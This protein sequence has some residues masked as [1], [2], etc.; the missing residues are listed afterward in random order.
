MLPRSQAGKRP[1]AADRVE[2]SAIFGDLLTMIK[3]KW[4]ENELNNAVECHLKSSNGT[5]RI[6]NTFACDAECRAMVG[7]NA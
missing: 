6:G 2:S 3:G 4:L 1:A 7:A 5:G